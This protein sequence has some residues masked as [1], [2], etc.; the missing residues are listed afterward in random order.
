M[1]SDSEKRNYS[2]YQPRSTEKRGGYQP[3]GT[4]PSTPPPP[5]KGSSGAVNVNNGSSPKK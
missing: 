3:K 2:G 1:T 4:Q 5:P